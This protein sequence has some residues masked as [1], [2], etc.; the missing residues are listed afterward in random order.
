[1]MLWKRKLSL[2][3]GEI[4]KLW[5]FEKGKR[6]NQGKI[7]YFKKR[8]GISDDGTSS[9]VRH[10]SVYK[11]TQLSIQCNAKPLLFYHIA[12]GTASLC[13]R[14]G[15]HQSV[16]A[17]FSKGLGGEMLIL[18]SFLRKVELLSSFCSFRWGSGK[19]H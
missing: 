17:K 6:G 15:P 7:W 4:L 13:R 16:E 8:K 12:T 11:S 1:M 18:A 5:Y 14:L 9:T 3:K 10:K 19:Y 2:W